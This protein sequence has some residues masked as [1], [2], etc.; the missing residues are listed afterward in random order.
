MKQ[1]I[2]FE[3]FDKIDL[4]IGKI[5]EV[6]KVPKAD[7]LLKL[8]VDLDFEKRTILSGIAEFYKPEDLIGKLVTVVV[9][10]APSKN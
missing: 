8:I 2:V 6:E 10:L 4:R 1:S 9:N 5:L 7:K 3:D